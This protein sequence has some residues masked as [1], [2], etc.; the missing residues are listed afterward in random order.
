MLT[1]VA[2]NAAVKRLSMRPVRMAQDGREESKL[3]RREPV[4][5]EECDMAKPLVLTSVLDT[6]ITD[7]NRIKNSP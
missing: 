6:T 5:S 4:E 3:L 1:A 7:S 2:S